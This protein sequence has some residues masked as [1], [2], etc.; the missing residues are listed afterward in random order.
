MRRI[1]RTMTE[2]RDSRFAMLAD[3]LGALAVF[4]MAFAA[5]HL[6]LMG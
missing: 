3:A 6:P 5:L 1:L 2:K 4:A